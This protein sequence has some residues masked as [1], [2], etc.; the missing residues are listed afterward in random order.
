[1]LHLNKDIVKFLIL[2]GILTYFYLS[3]S[4]FFK[5][6]KQDNKDINTLKNL[7][8]A[9]MFITI[10]GFVY[11]IS[12]YIKAFPTEGLILILLSVTTGYIIYKLT[13]KELSKYFIRYANAIFEGMTVDDGNLLYVVTQINNK[14][15]ELKSIDGNKKFLT[16]EEFNQSG[17]KKLSGEIA[18][19]TKLS[20]EKAQEL[21]EQNSIIPPENIAVLSKENNTGAIET[22]I[23]LKDIEDFDLI[24]KFHNYINS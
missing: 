21:V 24:E 11:W 9:A 14:G 1:M 23:I 5:S 8:L 13:Y 10:A 12:P 19:R 17:Y 18:I 15:I 3:A 22:D 16:F 7:L 4:L 2:S 20:P 6:I